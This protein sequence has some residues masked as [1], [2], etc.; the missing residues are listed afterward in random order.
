MLE[1]ATSYAALA[2]SFQWSIPA[3]FNIA[4]ACCDR[5]AARE[6]DRVALFRAHIDNR[7]TPITYGTLKRESDKL[8]F[9]LTVR[10]I[11]PGDRVAILLPQSVE[12]AVAH[13]AIYKAGAIAVPL[14]AL[15]GTEALRHRLSVS[16]TRLVVT[17][18][19]GFTK[20]SEILRDLPDLEAVL[21]TDGAS[22]M[23]EGYREALAAFG[24]PFIAA[25]TRPRDPAM[26]IFT[27]GTTGLPKGA[28]HGH[29]VLLGHL[30]GFSFSHEFFPE[31]GDRM[32][33]PSDWAWAGGLLNAL[34]PSLF[35]GVPVV[36]GPFQ[37]FDPE[38]AF[39]LM[40]GTGVRNAFLPPTAIK[41]LRSVREPRQRYDL[42]LRTIVSAGESLG[43]E[44]YEWSNA[45]LGI[46]VNEVYGQTECNYVIASSA[47]IGVSRAGAIGKPVPGHQVAIVDYEGRE[48]QR[49]VTGQIAIARPDPVMFLEYWEDPKATREKFIGDWL[50]TGDQ[51]VMES[52]GYVRF[53]GR[54]DDIITSAGY[55]IGPAEV[56]DCILA[57]PAV[58][59][60]AAVGKPDS[61]R[62]EVVKAYVVLKPGFSP[63]TE[64][65]AEIQN[66]VR[67][68]LSPAEYPRDIDFVGEIPLTT[69]GKVIRSQLREHA[70]DE[71]AHELERADGYEEE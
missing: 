23:A 9:A 58:A 35:F 37:R 13:F 18:G 69:S 31:P 12:A 71:A 5:W 26:M 21:C 45:E 57:H 54:D 22:G 32:W 48:V 46:T 10:G 55:R 41:L 61:L 27:S 11:G 44:A 7:T 65:A 14:A 17:D 43:R 51:G 40:A 8:A 6:P 33:T 60:A 63:S 67:E 2:R 52:D 15:F 1:R 25:D 59:L 39:A 36:F 53:I 4:V 47:A 56:E 50:A 28:L 62:T 20:L 30:P 16:G 34:L 24:Q 70:R 42:K 49:G 38:A 68:R 19:P 66:L 64:L 3:S 29:R